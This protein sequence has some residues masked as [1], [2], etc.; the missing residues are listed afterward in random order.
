MNH[1][2]E[3]TGL[4][5]LEGQLDADRAQEVKAHLSSCNALQPPPARART[6]KRLAA[7]LSRSGR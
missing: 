2:D 7:G 6:G 1:F 4:L 3:M 5:Y